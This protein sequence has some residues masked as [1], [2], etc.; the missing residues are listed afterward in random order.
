MKFFL[1]NGDEHVGGHGVPDLRLERVLAVAQK[2]LDTKVLFDPFEEQLHLPAA[3]VQSGHG[4]GRQGRV[5]GQE[6]Q[7]LLG[8][9][10]LEPDTSQV[11]GVVLRGVVT[12]QCDGFIAD[13]TAAPVHLGR[14]NAPGVHVAFGT[15]HKEGAGLM[16]LEQACK[17]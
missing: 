1:N 5:F 2:L 16:H 7:S 10:V 17:V 11:F 6:D 14:V 4:Q 8:C 9:W 15:G 3:F 12:I 13:K